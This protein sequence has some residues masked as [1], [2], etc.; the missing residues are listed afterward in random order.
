[1]TNAEATTTENAA[2]VAEPGAR[3][4]PEKASSKKDATPKKGAPKG[5]K[6]VKRGKAYAAAP[7]KESAGRPSSRSAPRG[8][9]G[10]ALRARERRS[11]R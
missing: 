7:K 2:A 10:R 1:M 8:P 11:W 6:G 9:P 4:A 3:V 5:H